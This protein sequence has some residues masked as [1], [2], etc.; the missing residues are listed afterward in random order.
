[1]TRSRFRLD[2]QLVENAVFRAMQAREKDCRA[3][4]HAAYRRRIDAVYDEDAHTG[5]GTDARDAA[6]RRLHGQMFDELGFHDVLQEVT[7]AVPLLQEGVEL[8][9]IETAERRSAEGAELFVRADD[10]EHGAVVRTLV[11]RLCPES[12]GDLDRLRARLTRELQHVADMLDPG[13]GYRPDLGTSAATAA[14]RNLIRDRYAVLWDVSIEGRL[15]RG[16]RAGERIG[17]PLVIP[18]PLLV[19]AEK[20][21]TGMA[22]HELDRRL[23]E[24]WDGEAASHARLLAL[25]QN[26]DTPDEPGAGRPGAPCP[27]CSF[28]THTWVGPD[29]E[30]CC[31]Q[32][33]EMLGIDVGTVALNRAGLPER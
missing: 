5:T 15:A 4:E 33:A 20:A 24:A 2:G 29:T 6:L 30:R 16:E 31:L 13:F 17:A 28:P 8:V 32:C 9:S 22:R 14:Q 18:Q 1:M 11:I 21:F 27:H 23:R 7:D 3:A 19:R 26:P 10:A 25:A 12:F